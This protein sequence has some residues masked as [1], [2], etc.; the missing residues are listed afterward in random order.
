MKHLGQCQE[1][2]IYEI[3]HKHTLTHTYTL[4]YHGSHVR[5]PLWMSARPGAV[6]LN[7]PSEGS[8]TAW[9]TVYDLLSGQP[10][11]GSPTPCTADQPVPHPT[12]PPGSRLSRTLLPLRVPVPHQLSPCLQ[13]APSGEAG[14]G[15]AAYQALLCPGTL[16]EPLA[17]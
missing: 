15:R 2:S 16:R 1:H 8:Q 6:A 17:A 10:W 9:L 13:K 5:V 11:K 4:T 12:V 3:K 14:G 7:L